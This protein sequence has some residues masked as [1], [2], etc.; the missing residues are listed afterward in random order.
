MGIGCWLCYFRDVLWLEPWSRKRRNS[1][2]GHCHCIHY[3]DVFGFHVQ[4]YRTGLRHSQAGGA[5]DY[6]GGAHCPRAPGF[7]VGLVQNIEF[8]FAPPAIAYAIG[9]YF[10]LFFPN[11]PILYIAIFAYI[12]FTALNI[13][14]IRAAA[15]FELVI[16]ILAVGEI[17]LFSGITLPHLKMSNLA[18]NAF[19]N[20]WE[21]VFTSIPFAI[22]FFLGIEGI[23]TW[24]R[25]PLHHKRP[26]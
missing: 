22:W 12:A 26:F 21:G 9:A 24:L 5:F 13:S 15:I 16:T 3:P 19:P 25:K 2:P 20:H 6:A 14:G 8:I 7:L 18:Q 10:N 4:L 23:E 17:L 11:L 1:W